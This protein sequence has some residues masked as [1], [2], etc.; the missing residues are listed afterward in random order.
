MKQL[1]IGLCAVLL[2]LAV[3]CT[4][5][6]KP[7]P[8]GSFTPVDDPSMIVITENNDIRPGDSNA[9]TDETSIVARFEGVTITRATYDAAKTEIQLVVEELNR[10]T[11][12]RDYTKWLTYL[13]DEYIETYSDPETLQ[14]V[15][16]SLPIRG[17]QLKSLR[18]YFF[19]VFV[20]SRQNM[21]VDDIQ[22]VSPTR[23]YAIMEIS[24]TQPVAIY[25]LERTEN[26]WQ[27]VVKN[28]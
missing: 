9:R 18:D 3:S 24:P 17:V 10:I 20:P 2:L 28:Q 6:A 5:T 7:Q 23:V 12:S 8:D 16:A 1:F 25:I 14:R 27:I 15:S 26:G 22:F 4:G 21:R 19:F 11:L 13:S